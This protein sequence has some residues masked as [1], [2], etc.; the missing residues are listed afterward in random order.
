FLL[1]AAVICYVI[2]KILPQ[3][4]VAGLVGAVSS[5]VAGIKI[6]S[7]IVRSVLYVALM[8]GTLYLTYK[9]TVKLF[10]VLIYVPSL[11]LSIL[12][13][14]TVVCIDL[15]KTGIEASVDFVTA[16]SNICVF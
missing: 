16:G 10:K 14:V 13:D 3:F 4:T 1:K 5:I 15:L 11:C 12:F 8:V 7:G 2:F 9:A 6:L